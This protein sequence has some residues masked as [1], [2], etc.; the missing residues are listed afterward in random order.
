MVKTSPSNANGAGLIP[1]G[2]LRSHM[3]C[4]VA[5]KKIQA[6]NKTQCHLR[7]DFPVA[8]MVETLPAIQETRV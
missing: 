5:K 4:S 7:W 6:T 8:Q 2:E 1:I 3:R